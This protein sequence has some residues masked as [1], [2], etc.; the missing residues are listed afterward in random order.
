MNKN[1]RDIN[2]RFDQGI[3]AGVAKALLEHKRAGPSLFP[4][5]VMAKW[6]GYPR[7]KLWFE[8]KI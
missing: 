7:K 6:S 2:K 4:S 5:G 3:R 8:K 1:I